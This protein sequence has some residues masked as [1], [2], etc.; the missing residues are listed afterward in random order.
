MKK[1]KLSK[2]KYIK[3]GLGIVREEGK[4]AVKLQDLR[5]EYEKRKKARHHPEYEYEEE[6]ERMKHHHK[7]RDEEEERMRKHP[8]RIRDEEE[9]EESIMKD[10]LE[11]VMLAQT[12]E[13]E[14][15]E[16][17][18]HGK[19]RCEEEEEEEEEM[20]E[21][22]EEE[23]EHKD[24]EDELLEKD[25]EDEEEPMGEIEI[26]KITNQDELSEITIGNSDES[27]LDLDTYEIFN[28][29]LSE[30]RF[31]MTVDDDGDEDDGVIINVINDE[32]EQSSELANEIVDRALGAVMEEAEMGMEYTDGEDYQIVNN[33]DGSVTIIGMV[34]E[35]IEHFVGD[36][37][38]EVLKD[39][40]SDDIEDDTTSKIESLVTILRKQSA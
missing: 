19:P 35:L 9:E 18:S 8:H 1:H 14:E 11:E 24:E 13:E 4:K 25:D 29:E 7:M 6:E 3:E 36:E 37:V 33:D 10:H 32:G 26:E 30:H 21:E 40:H 12:T 17:Y 5:D 38:N 20:K 16:D 15:K 31:I 23:E 34:P 2:K 28:P 22:E 39:L 27:I